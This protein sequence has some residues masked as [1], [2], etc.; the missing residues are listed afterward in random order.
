MWA[1]GTERAIGTSPRS[2][3]RGGRERRRIESQTV[4]S[5]PLDLMKEAAA[6]IVEGRD[7]ATSGG[8]MAAWRHGGLG[9]CRKEVRGGEERMEPGRMKGFSAGN[10]TATFIGR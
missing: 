10:R 4:A 7:G 2:S 5:Y 1:T 6:R 9:G 8:D 3:A